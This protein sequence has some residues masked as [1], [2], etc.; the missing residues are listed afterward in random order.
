MTHNTAVQACFSLRYSR[1]CIA[2]LI[3][4]E[5][6]KIPKVDLSAVSIKGKIEPESCYRQGNINSFIIIGVTCFQH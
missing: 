4:I 5:D 3:F 2:L 1:L 6:G